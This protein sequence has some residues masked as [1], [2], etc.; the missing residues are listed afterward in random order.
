MK[1][2]ITGI[3]ASAAWLLLLLAGPFPLF[4]LVITGL[5]AVALNEYLTIA[6]SELSQRIRVPIILFGLFPLL[7]AYSGAPVGLLCGLSLALVALL[8]FTL[9]RYSSLTLPFEVIS[10]GG[11]GYLYLGL[12]SAHLVLLMALP[13]GRAWLLLLTAIT[14]AS[15]TAAFYTG[16]KFGRHK[17][18]PAISP[19]KTWE[20]FLGGLAGSLLASLLVRHFFLPE[21]SILWICLIVLLLGCL[22]AAGDLSESVI[23]RAFGVKDSGSLLPGHGG[24]L[25]RI[26]S[27]LLTAPVLYYLLYFQTGLCLL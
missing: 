7:G 21:Q 27:L 8:L 12:C 10:R 16:S 24:L 13:Q 19:G 17:L 2:L 22:G 11:F 18:C 25:D 9:S 1:R 15:D 20:G 23:K 4:W 26:D 5:A 3:I 14:A 6:L